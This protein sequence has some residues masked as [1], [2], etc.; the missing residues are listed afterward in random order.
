MSSPGFLKTPAGRIAAVAAGLGVLVY[1]LRRNPAGTVGPRDRAPSPHVMSKE[2]DKQAQQSG[3]FAGNW[4]GQGESPGSTC[5][6]LVVLPSRA[7]PPFPGLLCRRKD[8]GGGGAL[9]FRFC[10]HQSP[11]Q[12]CVS[13]SPSPVQAPTRRAAARWRR[14]AARLA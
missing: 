10:S 7:G 13:A 9:R 6:P 11:P 3:T 8:D 1:A 2:L 5:V 14:G 12:V 4:A